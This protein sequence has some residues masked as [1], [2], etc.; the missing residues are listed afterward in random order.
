MRALLAS[1]RAVEAMLSFGFESCESTASV[2]VFCRVS[3]MFGFEGAIKLL[4][5]VDWKVCDTG[6]VGLGVYPKRLSLRC[7]RN[8]RTRELTVVVQILRSD[9][10]ASVKNDA[11]QPGRR[12]AFLLAT[13][14]S[15]S[16]ERAIEFSSD[17]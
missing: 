16:M 7:W 10:R 11:L 9:V 8:L 6:I 17:L 5:T 15:N 12:Q 3:F 14:Q 1:R 4:L 2:L 13:I